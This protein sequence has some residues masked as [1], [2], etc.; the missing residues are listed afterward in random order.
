MRVLFSLPPLVTDI[1]KAFNLR[2]PGKLAYVEWFSKLAA[3]DSVTGMYNVRRS[4]KTGAQSDVRQATI[5]EAINLRR[6]AHL[7]AKLSGHKPSI[8]LHLTSYNILERWPDFW[9]NNFVDKHAYRT[10]Y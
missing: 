1:F 7:V 3:P 9:V 10:I 2:T 6:S 5:V 4:F 8:P